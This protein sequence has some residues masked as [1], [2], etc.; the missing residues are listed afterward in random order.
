MAPSGFSKKILQEDSGIANPDM[1]ATEFS[2]M[3]LDSP[4][5]SSIPCKAH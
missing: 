2:Q 5:V 1:R 3:D 4:R